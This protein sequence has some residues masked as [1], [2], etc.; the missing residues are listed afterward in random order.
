MQTTKWEVS[1]QSR[2]WVFSLN[3]NE[4]VAAGTQTAAVISLKLQLGPQPPLPPSKARQQVPASPGSCCYRCS[5]VLWCS[6]APAPTSSIT[7]QALALSTSSVHSWKCFAVM[8]GFFVRFK[9]ANCFSFVKISQT[10]QLETVEE[11]EDKHHGICFRKQLLR[12]HF[13]R[14]NLTKKQGTVQRF[15]SKLN[16]GVAV[17]LRKKS[18][19]PYKSVIRLCFVIIL[20]RL[21]NHLHWKTWNWR[22]AWKITGLICDLSV[23]LE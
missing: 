17:L 4:L 5:C 13:K 11:K 10:T 20:R 22:T 19:C 23:C 14:H 6:R 18:C 16:L 2:K 8:W 9:V 7:P 3:W 1:A 15:F 12:R 21:L